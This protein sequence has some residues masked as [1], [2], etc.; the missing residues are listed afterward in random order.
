MANTEISGLT[1]ITT[2]ASD[3]VFPVVDVS[4]SVTKKITRD[5]LKADLNP[6]PSGTIM[7]FGQNA[8]PTGWTRKAD[9][10]DNAMLCYAAS[11]NIG[12][13]GGVDPQATHTHAGGSHALTVAEMPSH[14]HNVKHYYYSMMGG[15]GA[16][17]V[18]RPLNGDTGPVANGMS[19]DSVGGGSAHDHGNTG[20]NTAPYYQEVIAATKD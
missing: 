11:G 12:S 17:S 13:G 3:D 2:L 18:C 9:W 8:A 10:Q 15:S 20:A 16:Y 1:S 7:L 19:E 4:G 5:N 14:D 6:F